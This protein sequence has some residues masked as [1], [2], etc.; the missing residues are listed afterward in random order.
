M[1][2]NSLK[3]QGEFEASKWTHFYLSFPFFVFFS[4]MYMACRIT[5]TAFAKL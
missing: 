5:V 3:V 4:D 2:V 1:I